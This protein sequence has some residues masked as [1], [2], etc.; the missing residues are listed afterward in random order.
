MP[1]TLGAVTAALVAEAAATPSEAGVG[2]GRAVLDRLVGWL[3]RVFAA[4]DAKQGAAALGLVVDTPDA[5][6][7]LAYVLNVRADA[8]AGFPRRPGGAGGGGPF[9]RGRHRFDHADGLGRPERAGRRVSRLGH[10]HRARA[11]TGIDRL[12]ARL[13]FLGTVCCPP[14]WMGMAATRSV[15]TGQGR[16]WSSGLSSARI[17]ARRSRP[18]GQTSG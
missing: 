12:T 15:G 3:R 13:A 11:S 2:A 16:R 1:L 4:D 9:C 8:D 6:V 17:R 18:A 14:R 10:H 5:L 7:E